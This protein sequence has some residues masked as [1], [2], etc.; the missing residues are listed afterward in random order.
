MSSFQRRTTILDGIP[1]LG[2]WIAE[3][4]DVVGSR[5]LATDYQNNTGRPLLVI[6]ILYCNEADGAEN[7][8]G[9]AC[10]G[11]ATLTGCTTVDANKVCSC[12]FT[13]LAGGSP[14][15]G[16]FPLVFM[17]PSGSHYYL[18]STVGGANTVT[19]FEWWEVT[20]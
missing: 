10:V 16:Y 1:K 3:I 9:R 4:N 5:A 7:A 8:W 18:A 6:V 2:S 15:K 19:V 14:K 11:T 13:T 20:L 17:V 12:G